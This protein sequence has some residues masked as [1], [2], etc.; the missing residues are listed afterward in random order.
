MRRLL[1]IG[2]LTVLISGRLDA[3]GPA[4][5]YLGYRPGRQAV[6]TGWSVDSIHL[7][8]P[9]PYDTAM[10]SVSAETLMLGSEITY[11]GQTG[12]LLPTRTWINGRLNYHVDTTYES[13]GVWLKQPQMLGDTQVIINRY[14]VPL[15]SGQWWRFGM[16]GVYRYDFDGNGTEDTVDVR[17]DTSSVVG[18]E[19]VSTPFGTVPSCR[20]IRTVSRVTFTGTMQGVLAR[21]S[22]RLTVTSW[23]KDS[24]WLVKDSTSG[25]GAIY[26]YLFSL[27]LRAGSSFQYAVREL[28]ALEPT[29][30]AEQRRQPAVV[31]RSGPNPFRGEC[32]IEAAKPI[33]V[34]IYDAGGRCVFR[35]GPCRRVCWRPQGLAPAVYYLVAGAGNPPRSLVVLP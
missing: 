7:T 15:D 19:D 6:T 12:Y 23:Y 33:P 18:V 8:L 10:H 1:L 31:V 4:G 26:V 14:L 34:A 25:L 11:R 24:L 22:L 9:L 30:V 28:V 20:K 27:W 3:V 17:G 29:G 21:D 2:A 13:A 35:S 32:V 5:D 16:E